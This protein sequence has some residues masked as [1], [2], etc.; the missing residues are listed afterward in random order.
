MVRV[1]AEANPVYA[2]GGVAQFMDIDWAAADQKLAGVLSGSQ[3]QLF[4][5][6]D[7]GGA[8]RHSARMKVAFE[9][10]V[11]SEQAVRAAAPPPPRN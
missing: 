11:K 4:Q 10:A 6:I 7:P 3:L 1:L 8:G 5:Q 9:A 2:K